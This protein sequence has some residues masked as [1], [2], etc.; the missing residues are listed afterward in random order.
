MTE[1]I[2]KMSSRKIRETLASE[3]KVDNEN[4]NEDDELV[5]FEKSYTKYFRSVWLEIFKSLK[6]D[7]NPPNVVIK[8]GEVLRLINQLTEVII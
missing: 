5:K 8:I 6:T 4:E 2:R 7:S 3:E 1:K